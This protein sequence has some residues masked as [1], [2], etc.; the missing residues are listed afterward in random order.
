VS[1]KVTQYDQHAVRCRCGKVHTATRPEGARDG[2]VGHG[3]NLQ[4]LAVLMMVGHFLPA[5]RCVALLEALTG[6][7]PSVGFVHGMLARTA[8]LLAAPV[9]RIRALVVKARAVRCDETPIRVGPRKPKPGRK[10]AEKHL[11]AACAE[12]RTHYLVGDRDLDT[13]KAFA[14]KDLTGSVVVH[15]R[16]QV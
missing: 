12:L 10:K 13:F 9:A 1:A 4:A 8:G 15:D 7:A 14:R 2:V 16:C 6:A 3:P 5:R 11:L